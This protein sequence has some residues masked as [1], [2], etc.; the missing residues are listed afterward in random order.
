MNVAIYYHRPLY[1]SS[2]GV[3]RVATWL[4]R[5]LVAAG[6][7]V[8]CFVPAGF[9][10][11]GVACIGVTCEKVETVEIPQGTIRQQRKFVKGAFRERGITVVFNQCGVYKYSGVVLG[12]GAR[13]ITTH[14]SSTDGLMF[15][16]RIPHGTCAFHKG[17]KALG[18]VSMA[19]AVKVYDRIMY[20]RLLPIIKRSDVFTFLAPSYRD[21]MVRYFPEYA[22]RFRVI[23]N[24]IPFEHDNLSDFQNKVLFVGRVD[25]E[26]RVERLIEAWSRLPAQYANWELQIVGTGNE[27]EK[28]KTLARKKNLANVVFTGRADVREYY[29]HASIIC[30]TSDVEGVPM[31]LREAMSYGIAPIIFNSFSA[32]GEMITD[33]VN[34]RLIPAFDIDAYV[35]ALSELMD[36]ETEKMRGSI[37]ESA[38]PYTGENVFALW[39]RLL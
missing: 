38:K 19:L 39:R 3:G 15:C 10:V 24:P 9:R 20:W 27:L 17:L 11:D 21:W 6:H 7:R 26:K 16:G 28:I 25:S 18:M 23:S 31:V 8:W 1:E 5:Q 29:S 33:H 12:C 14:H 35:K 34:G 13:V 36:G 4:A 2:G 32:A 22:D 37:L 30:L